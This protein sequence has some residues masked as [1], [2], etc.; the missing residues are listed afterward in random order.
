MN[1]VA[2]YANLDAAEIQR[3]DKLR[4]LGLLEI[5]PVWLPGGIHELPPHLGW[6]VA[7]MIDETIIVTFSSDAGKGREAFEGRPDCVTRSTDGGETWSAPL[8][9]W[10]RIRHP[11]ARGPGM[12]A[13]GV[14]PEG[15]VLI[16]TSRG[17]FVSDDRGAT[18]THLDCQC[19]PSPEWGNVGPRIVAHPVH[20]LVMPAHAFGHEHRGD[21]ADECFHLFVS[22]DQGMHWQTIRVATPGHFGPAEPTAF[23]CDGKLAV[24]SRNHAGPS[25]G[26]AGYWRTWSYFAQFT[27]DDATAGRPLAEQAWTCKLTNIFNRRMDTPDADYNPVSGRIEAVISK[28]NE[29]FPYPDNAYQTLSLWSIDPAAFFAGDANWRFDGVLL[30]SKGTQGRSRH[31]DFP[32]REGLH[33]AGAVIDEKRNLQHIFFFAGNRT[34]GG[35]DSGRTGIFRLSRTLDSQ[36]LRTALLRTPNAAM[37]SRGFADSFATLAHWTLNGRPLGLAVDPADRDVVRRTI[38]PLPEGDV[39]AG[40]EGLRIRTRAPGHYGLYHELGTVLR[41]HTVTIKVRFL[42]C[43]QAGDSLGLVVSCGSQRL[44]IVWR[45]DGLYHRSARDQPPVRVC[46]LAM[47]HDWHDWIVS[48]QG[49]TAEVAM[50]GRVL[51]RVPS[52]VDDWLGEDEAPLGLNVRSTSAD[53]PVDVRVATVTLENHEDS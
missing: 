21:G 24:F 39:S 49:G 4:E 6:P 22:H 30:R 37:D 36:C 13:I 44:H 52:L 3:Q 8:R 47:D 45:S 38:A 35:P 43:A 41:D 9:L 19:L 16:S 51:A 27:P 12:R 40:D 48:M 34:H 32:P 2:T 23:L 53:D 20:G 5:E 42:R 10:E 26:R 17:I 28:R 11:D 46:D 25:T 33:P 29:G 7:A 31:P 1:A 14:T 18:W 15:G 50:D